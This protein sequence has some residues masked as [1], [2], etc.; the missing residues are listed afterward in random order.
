MMEVTAR[1]MASGSLSAAAPLSV[2]SISARADVR[3]TAAGVP[4]A[5]ASSAASP[6]VSCGPGERDIGGRKDAR[7]GVTAA[8]EA[9]E[10]HGQ[11]GGL[12]F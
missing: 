8:D 9:G 2:V 4:H 10:V 6:N 11:S 1:A 3:D 12:A 7:D 5:S